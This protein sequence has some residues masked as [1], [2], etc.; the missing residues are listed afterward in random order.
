MI[1][2]HVEDLVDT[3]RNFDY[4]FQIYEEMV[5]AWLEREKGL[6]E[7]KDALR[8]FSERLAVDLFVNR[9]ARG[10]ERIAEA[11]LKPLAEQYGIQL[12]A[13][14]LRG[15][16]LLNRDAVGNYKFAHRSIMEYLFIRRFASDL[17]QDT[18][19]NRSQYSE[20]WTDLMK[21]FF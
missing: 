2:A 20:A 5:N 9:R 8:D 14:Q 11:E 17:R 19:Q 12:E 10:Q 4:R 13:W 3:D 15:R 21:T 16:S 1:L 18:A 7:N 6:V